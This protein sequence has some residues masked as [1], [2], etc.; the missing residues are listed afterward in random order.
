MRELEE[1]WG[2]PDAKGT[3]EVSG[4]DA[5]VVFNDCLLFLVGRK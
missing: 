3:G 4:D 1:D 5:N 2:A